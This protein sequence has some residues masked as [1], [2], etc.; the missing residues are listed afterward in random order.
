MANKKFVTIVHNALGDAEGIDV[1]MKKLK[2]DDSFVR[3]GEKVTFPTSPIRLYFA[4]AEGDTVALRDHYVDIMHNIWEKLGVK[5]G[6]ASVLV[7]DDWR[8]N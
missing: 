5:S 7:G 4:E 1:E 8:V 3:D 6:I 2:F